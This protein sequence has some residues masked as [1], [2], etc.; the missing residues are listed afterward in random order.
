MKLN[1]FLL[2]TDNTTHTFTNPLVIDEAGVTLDNDVSGI[3]STVG[4]L[5]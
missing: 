1:K 3:I 5:E 2:Q 4:S